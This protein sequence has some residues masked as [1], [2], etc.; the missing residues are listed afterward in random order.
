MTTLI[1]CSCLIEIQRIDL[2][3]RSSFV[4]FAKVGT[5]GFFDLRIFPFFVQGPHDSGHILILLPA[6]LIAVLCGACGALYTRLNLALNRKRS[7]FLNQASL[8]K[9]AAFGI[10][11]K[12][13]ETA[14]VALLWH[15]VCVLTSDFFPC[16]PLPNDSPSSPSELDPF[17][18]HPNLFF[19]PRETNITAASTN[20][21]LL[22]MNCP[23]GFYNDFASLALVPGHAAIRALFA[24]GA[25][26]EVFSLPA[27]LAFLLVYFLFSIYCAGMT[28]AGG[29]FVPML[30]IGGLCGRALALCLRA[31]NPSLDAQVWGDP[32]LLALLGAAA[33]GSGLSRLTMALT[34]IVLEISGAELDILPIMVASTVAKWVADRLAPPLY[35]AL[36]DIKCV[37]FL[38]GEPPSEFLPGLF[39][40]NDVMRRDPICLPLCVRVGSVARLLEETTHNGFPVCVNSPSIFVAGDIK[41]IF[42][43]P[44]L[45]GGGEGGKHVGIILRAQLDILLQYTQLHGVDEIDARFRSRQTLVSDYHFRNAQSLARDRKPCSLSPAQS[46]RFLDLTPYVNTSAVTLSHMFDLDFAYVLF[47]SLGLRHVTVVNFDNVPC[48]IVT[49][50]D[51]LLTNSKDRVAIVQKHLIGLSTHGSFEPGSVERNLGLWLGGKK[52]GEPSAMVPVNELRHEIEHGQTYTSEIY[53][54]ESELQFV[55]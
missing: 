55:N 51:L 19:P 34:V 36:L 12:L 40:I 5:F 32:G 9:G 35:H 42:P 24:R 10:G 28:T 54:R 27:L 7:V 13:F 23:E 33:F 3:R 43:S 21:E 49:R 2:C 41:E 8:T 18:F 11:L 50:K 26:A 47:R 30:L 6:L 48:G 37:P 44:S 15:S 1:C 20:T 16:R 45:R 31:I 25:Q 53:R 29:T 39:T 4:A 46:E 38:P 17:S 52:V 14:L 22:Q